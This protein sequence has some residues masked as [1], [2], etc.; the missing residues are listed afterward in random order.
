LPG[1]SYA[2][3]VALM[4]RDAPRELV[5]FHLFC[6]G[7]LAIAGT[8][9]GASC[10]SWGRSVKHNASLE[11]SVKDSKH[12][13]WTAADLVW[14]PGSEPDPGRLIAVARELGIAAEHQPATPAGE[15]DHWHLEILTT[16]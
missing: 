11:G 3:A 8:F 9:A 16:I 2:L 13:V 5:R 1:V 7:V 4:A 10:T 15:H 12:L 14:D 6:E